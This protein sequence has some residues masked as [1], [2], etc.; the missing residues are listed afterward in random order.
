[1][2]HITT[3]TILI[4]PNKN[5]DVSGRGQHNNINIRNLLYVKVYRV[6]PGDVFK[7][8]NIKLKKKV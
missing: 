8:I 6:N 3:T 4:L 7:I 2:H 5:I 1:M